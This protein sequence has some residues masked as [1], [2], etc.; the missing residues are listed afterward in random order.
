MGYSIKVSAKFDHKNKSAEKREPTG[1]MCVAICKPVF[2][3][4]PILVRRE[5]TYIIKR[6]GISGIFRFFAGLQLRSHK[7]PGQTE[8]KPN[9]S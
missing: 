6:D 4:L 2:G 8:I 9:L 3:L 5:T 1:R 7:T